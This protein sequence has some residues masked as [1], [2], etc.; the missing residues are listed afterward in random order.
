MLV[1]TN[2]AMVL[3][4]ISFWRMAH[5]QDATKH[6]QGWLLTTIGGIIFLLALWMTI[7]ACI[8][9]KHPKEQTS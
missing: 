5:G 2:W 9:F 3:N 7:E 4:E 6:G 1:I 8:A